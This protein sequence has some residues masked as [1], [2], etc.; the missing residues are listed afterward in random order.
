MEIEAHISVEERAHGSSDAI[1]ARGTH[2]LQL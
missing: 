1:Q 2:I